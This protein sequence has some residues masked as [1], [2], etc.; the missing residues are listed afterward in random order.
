MGGILTNPQFRERRF[1]FS[2]RQEAGK[3]LGAYIR[4]HL[5]YPDPV[6]LAIPAGGVPVGKG[7]AQALGAPLEL[8]IVRKIQIPGN[9]EAGFGAITWDGQ[10]LINERLRAALDLPQDEVD[11]AVALTRKNVQE[12]IARFTGGRPFPDLTG[13]TAILV[14][15]GL[16]SGFTML[17]A[18]HS[19]RILRPARIIVAVPTA[20][21]SSAERIAAESDQLI[22][23]NIRS[24][25][26]FAVAE[27]YEKWYDLDDREVL[28]EMADMA[29][30]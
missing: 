30:R 12:R 27:A 28:R 3:K 9:T 21:A 4:S 24:T 26:Q 1:V 10:V 15:D 6:V 18:I 5:E 22:C 14:D 13:K 11:A 16:A 8:A 20:S 23:L 2:D 29:D 25:R 7:V 17:A 19:I